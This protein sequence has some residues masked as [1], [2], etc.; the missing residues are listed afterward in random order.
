ML[1][2]L[3]KQKK[4]P[5]TPV[6]VDIPCFRVASETRPTDSVEGDRGVKD[7]K[8]IIPNQFAGFCVETGDAFLFGDVFADTSDDV[9][10]VIKDDRCGTSDEFCFPEQVFTFDRPR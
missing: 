4:S 8:L 10:S 6:C 7:V 1:P 9:D 3:S 2:S 5:W